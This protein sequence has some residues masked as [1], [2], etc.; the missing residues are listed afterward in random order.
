MSETPASAPEEQEP[1]PRDMRPIVVQDAPPPPKE[2]L[3]DGPRDLTP[4]SWGGTYDP[5][6]DFRPVQLPADAPD[7]KDLSAAVSA[8]YSVPLVDE[9][10][11]DA[12]ATTADAGRVST[13]VKAPE[14]SKP[15]SSPSP[16]TG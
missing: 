8:D 6:G 15:P 7:P 4:I 3:E 2:R 9:S 1:V 5:E 10:Q 14:L 12:L 11:S 13:P 16:K